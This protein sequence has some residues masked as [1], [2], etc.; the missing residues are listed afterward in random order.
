MTGRVVRR[1]QVYRDALEIALYIADDNPAAGERFLDALEEAY[2]LLREHPEAG[3]ACDIN[4]SDER[5]LRSWPVKRFESYLV[6]YFS[7]ERKSGIEVVRILH[8]A[9]ELPPLLE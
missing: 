3:H 6:F 4:V 1:P 5:T 2:E 8:G 9:R 7:L